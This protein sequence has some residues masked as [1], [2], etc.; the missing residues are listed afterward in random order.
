MSQ[1]EN[2]SASKARP[3]RQPRSAEVAQK[4][5]RRKS[6]QK[7]LKLAIPPE[8]RE[9]FPE[10][11]FRWARDDGGRMDELTKQDDWDKVPDV[12][13]VHGGRGIE[14]KGVQMHLLMKP[15]EFMEEDRKEKAER[16][17]N[18]TKAQLARPE[19]DQAVQQ[20][21]EHYSVP[22]NKLS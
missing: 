7:G 11:E 12:K 21:A 16:V 19:K 4:R 6:G 18:I 20:G 22:G 13:T 14:G 2:E 3:G 1:N 17:A 8:V 9:K 15:K 5:R 10:H